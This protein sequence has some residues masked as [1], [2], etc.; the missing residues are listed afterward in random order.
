M[1]GSCLQET[2]QRAL[3]ITSRVTPS[4]TP[5]PIIQNTLI[6]MIEKTVEFTATNLE[7]TVRMRIP[8]DVDREGAL[9][10]PNKLL[11]DL[12]NTL[13]REPVNMEQTEK[14]A[15]MQIKCGSAKANINGAGAELFPPTPEVEENSVVVITAE[16]FRK[17]VA[18]VAFCAATDNGRP[19]LTGVLMELDGK[20]LTTVGADGFRLGLQRSNLESPPSEGMRAI[21]PARTLLEVQRIAGNAERQV[22]IMIPETGN[23]I[24]FLVGSEEPGVTEVEVTSLLL[25][26]TYPDYESLIPKELPNK[27][28]FNLGDLSRTARRADIFAK[29]N[30]H[31]I[32]FDINRK[33]GE[34]GSA[35]I[36]SEAKDLGN[37]RAELNVEEMHGTDIS[38]ALNGKYIQEAL[39]SLDSKLVTLETSTSSNPTRIGI[40]DDESYVHVMMP[41]VTLESATP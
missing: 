19:V 40:P 20:T 25:A 7:M 8:A 41:I 31:T 6:R 27:A 14:T 21:V 16:E 29:D 34:T 35:I 3:Q 15:V 32:R 2:M 12:V 24:R 22:E 1:K 17:A 18:R 13:P 39:T 9:T 10:L 37:N 4:R 11:S 5:M 33:H 36:S 28:V 38:I 23:N 30:N 26:G